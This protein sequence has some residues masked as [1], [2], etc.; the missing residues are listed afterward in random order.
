MVNWPVPLVRLWGEVEASKGP[1]QVLCTGAC[2]S[3]LGKLPVAPGLKWL[4]LAM[5]LI[6]NYVDYNSQQSLSAV[7]RWC[8]TAGTVPLRD[9][10]DAAKRQE[11]LEQWTRYAVMR[12]LPTLVLRFQHC[13]EGLFADSISGTAVTIHPSLTRVGRTSYTIQHKVTKSDSQQLLALVETV[14]VQLDPS[15]SKAVPLTCSDELRNL[16]RDV[17]S[18]AERLPET[19]AKRP[20]TE[21]C[22]LWACEVRPSDC[23]LLGHMNNANYATLFDDARHA[24]GYGVDDYVLQA[25]AFEKLTIAVWRGVTEL[26]LNMEMINAAGATVARAFMAVVQWAYG[27]FVAS[28]TQAVR[29]LDDV[30]KE[31]MRKQFSDSVKQLMNGQGQAQINLVRRRSNSREHRRRRTPERRRSPERERRSPRRSASPPKR[32]EAGREKS[33]VNDAEGETEETKCIVV[34]SKARQSTGERTWRAE[35]SVPK[36]ND[37]QFGGKSR[38]MCIRGPLRVDKDPSVGDPNEGLMGGQRAHSAMAPSAD[39]LMDSSRLKMHLGNNNPMM[40]PVLQ[41][42]QGF[43]VMTSRQP[44]T[45]GDASQRGRS[46]LALAN[47]A[48]GRAMSL[49]SKMPLMTNRGEPGVTRQS[50][51]Q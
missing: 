46:P 35:I 38:T 6:A 15:L 14:M 33:P 47:I 20:A 39:K 7:L 21:E 43:G 24:A 12:S 17:Q 28:P 13:Q 9:V 32:L 22:Y 2:E 26:H 36:A 16:R 41:M 8:D 30:Q 49:S 50:S 48:E 19:F 31:D 37:Y 42:Q 45:A 5:E 23:D 4:W 44:T 3:H 29:E 18:L 34:E 1:S 10:A 51:K 40:V 11:L 25:Q 27:S